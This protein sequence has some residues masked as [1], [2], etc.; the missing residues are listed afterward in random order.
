MAARNYCVRHYLI[1]MTLFALLC[2]A[3][4]A[5]PL[6]FMSVSKIEI[7]DDYGNSVIAEANNGALSKVSIFANGKVINIDESCLVKINNVDLTTLKAAFDPSD[8]KAIAVV[9]VSFQLLDDVDGDFTASFFI[10]NGQLEYTETIDNQSG[11]VRA[12]AACIKP[13]EGK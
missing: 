1:K 4:H 13:E 3:S 2:G 9:R 7:H 8:M 6:I 12:L 5:T 10:K 11:K